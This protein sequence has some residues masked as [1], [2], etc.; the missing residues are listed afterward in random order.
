MGILDRHCMIPMNGDYQRCVYYRDNHHRTCTRLE[1]VAHPYARA[2]EHSG[3][4]QRGKR[5]PV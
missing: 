4:I 3:V 5:A 2:P 1:A